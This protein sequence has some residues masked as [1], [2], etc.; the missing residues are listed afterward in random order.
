METQL[1]FHEAANIFQLMEEDDFSE[2]VESI[3]AHGLRESIKTHE[4]KVIDGRNR[5]TACGIAGVKPRF[6]VANVNGSAAD[7]VHDLNY[8]RRHLTA[9]GK[10]MAAARYKEATAKEAKERQK[11]HGDTAPG[12]PKNTGGNGATSDAP[13]GKARDVAG[14][15][16]GVSG[17]TVDAA[18]R[19]AKKAA[20][21]VVK[22]VER[23]TMPVATAARL[24]AAPKSVQTAAVAEG[25]AAVRKAIEQHAPTIKEDAK[26]DAGTRWHK[27][28]RE[29]TTQIVSIREMGGIKVLVARW[30]SEQREEYRTDIEE[31]IQE[32]QSWNKALTSK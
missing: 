21:E 26:N 2:L 18:E 5:Y 8:T 13:K 29:L 14:K 19:V 28:M 32:L 22:A 7:Y 16:Y 23:G 3:R 12:K 25:K 27:A 24:S 4:G 15:K 6:E 10:A 31:L 30:T 1:E 9:G 20:P 17:K 11:S